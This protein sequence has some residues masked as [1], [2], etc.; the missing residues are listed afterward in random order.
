MMPC[1]KPHMINDQ[2]YSYDQNIK[3]NTTNDIFRKYLFFKK[4][5]KLMRILSKYIVYFFRKIDFVIN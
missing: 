2:I 3:I 4:K 5:S 1:M